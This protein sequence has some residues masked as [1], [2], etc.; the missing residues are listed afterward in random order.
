MGNFFINLPK[1]KGPHPA[2]CLFP[3][4]MPGKVLYHAATSGT[5]IETDQPET[6]LQRVDAFWLV[7][8]G[9]LSLAQIF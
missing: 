2:G 1:V 5:G 6:M 7:G 3:E 8:D 9:G 4:L